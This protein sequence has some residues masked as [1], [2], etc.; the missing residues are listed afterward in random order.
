MEAAD[1][2]GAGRRSGSLRQLIAPRELAVPDHSTGLTEAAVEEHLH[3]CFAPGPR[4][5]I[6]VEIE[7]MAAHARSSRYAD[8][9]PS[10]ELLG[11]GLSGRVS[12]EPGGQ[13]EL[14]SA[15]SASLAELVGTVKADLVPLRERAVAHGIELVGVGFDAVRPL[16]RVL[17]TPRYV[18]MEEYWRPWEPF[19]RRMMCATA[20]V[21]VNVEAGET[22]QQIPGR[23]DLLYAIGPTLA[24][25][26]ANSTIRPVHRALSRMAIWMHLDPARTGVPSARAHH[27]VSDSYAQWAMDAP[28]MLVQRPDGN[29]RAPRGASLH[30]WIRFGDRVV[31]DRAAPT[32]ADLELHLSTLFPFVR[33][34]GFFE[35]RYI[36]SL[37]DDGWMV[38]TAVLAAL[39]NDDVAGDRAREI[40]EGLED[41]WA[42]SAT[43]GLADPDLCCAANRLLELA[44]DNL[45]RSAQS[46]E[47]A[48]IIDAF[49]ESWTARALGPAGAARTDREVEGD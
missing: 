47:M 15:P 12:F 36:D 11:E 2:G 46:R 17:D 44:A 16:R 4:G 49:R 20:S 7:F 30:D 23:W 14:S 48:S 21:Q 43:R 24:A 41:H 13:I 8:A 40:C 37:P 27:S 18:A 29:W 26:F 10:I 33:P 3:A 32:V 22:P 25:T 19:G 6:G 9:L 34:R 39:T 42:I 28:L 45:R 35:V 31:P 1:P 38:P 5:R